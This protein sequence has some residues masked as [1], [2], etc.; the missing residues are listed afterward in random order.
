MRRIRWTGHVVCMGEIRN[1]YKLQTEGQYLDERTI[2]KWFL[3]I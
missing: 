1:K 3:K 2:L